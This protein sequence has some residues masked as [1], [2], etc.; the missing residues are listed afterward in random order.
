MAAVAARLYLGHRL[1]EMCTAQSLKHSHAL[2]G[3]HTLGL[4]SGKVL[5]NHTLR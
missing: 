5:N 2:S 1:Y 3:S 4:W